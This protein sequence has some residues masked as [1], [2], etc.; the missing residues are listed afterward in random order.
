M[1]LD[2]FARLDPVL[3][4]AAI[5]SAMFAAWHVGSWIGR[6]EARASPPKEKIENAST[7]AQVCLSL[8]S[9]LLAFCFATGY[10]KY[11]ARRLQTVDEAN[12]IGTLYRRLEL[13][14]EAPRA[15]AQADL[16]EYVRLHQRAVASELQRTER[17]AVE[18]ELRVVQERFSDTLTRFLREPSAAPLVITVM[19]SLNAVVDQYEARVAGLNAHVPFAV[20]LLLVVT[21]VL[22][23]G[24]LGWV[25]GLSLKVLPRVT[26]TFLLLITLS[27]YVT[28]DLD[29][30]FTGTSRVSELPMQR[31]A[32]SIGVPAT[33]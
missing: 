26:L 23:L 33:P 30:P 3:L 12:A 21:S 29:Q 2:V 4:A 9:L 1:P 18:R 15:S 10:Q 27:L 13:L 19:P 14:P 28:F 24:L 6:R 8:A 31:L 5:G 17:L 11:E 7:V 20:L 32:E 25:E 22:A 16:R